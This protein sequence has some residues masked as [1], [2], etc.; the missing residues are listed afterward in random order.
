MSRN[1]RCEFNSMSMDFQRQ[2]FPPFF[3]SIAASDYSVLDI[4]LDIDNI[5]LEQGS[6]GFG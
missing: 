2:H 3:T 5:F 4:F 1:R 6:G